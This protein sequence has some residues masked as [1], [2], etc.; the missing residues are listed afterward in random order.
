MLWL[1]WDQVD[2]LARIFRLDPGETKNDEPR[3]LPLAGELYEMLVLQ[4]QIRNQ[5]WPDCPWVFFRYGKRIKDF[6]GAWEEASKRAGLWNDET[7]SP[8]ISFTTYA[9]QGQG[10][11]YVLGCPN[12]W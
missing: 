8:S 2:L 6:R 12:A 1:R 11:W 4:K 10:S 5:K 7:G 9:A 3:T